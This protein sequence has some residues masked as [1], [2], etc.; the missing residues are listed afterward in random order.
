MD[1]VSQGALQ[2]VH[3]EG[4]PAVVPAAGAEPMRARQIV[5]AFRARSRDRDTMG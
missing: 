4:L 1:W 2:D 5:G 3:F